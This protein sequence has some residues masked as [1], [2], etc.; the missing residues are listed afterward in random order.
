MSTIDEK[1]VYDPDTDPETAYVASDSGVATVS[2]VGER[3]GGVSLA[4]REPARDVATSGER[5]V[6]ATDDDVVELT[7][8]ESR[9]LDFGPATAVAI[10]DRGAVL[11]AGE[12]RLARY[13][14]GENAAGEW[15]SLG[16]LSAGEIRAIDGDLVASSEGAYR[17]A[18]GEVRYSGLG[19]VSDVTSAGT[20]H[21]A[22]S[23]GLY[24]LA[25]GWQGVLEGAFAVVTGDPRTATPSALGR[26]HAISGDGGYEYGGERWQPRTLPTE[27]S[28]VD[29]A[30][31]AGVYAVTGD[32]TLLTD[33][34]RGWREHPVGVRGVRAIAVGGVDR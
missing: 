31:G 8:G 4:R 11:A 30:Y 18:G 23:D 1:R 32:G 7:N 19:D 26:A 20:P 12:R 17:I 33:V 21:A 29:V 14:A 24:A 25:N 15:R 27:Q 34:G 16:Q 9:K 5:V 3:V 28:V 22:T 10:D 2:L 6:V 13:A